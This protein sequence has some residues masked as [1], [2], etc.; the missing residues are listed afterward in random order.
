VVVF[1][2]AEDAEDLPLGDRERH[3]VHRDQRPVGLAQV[4]DL[5]RHDT[6]NR[7]LTDQQY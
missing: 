2:R 1:V 6:H 4:R 5:D 7:L 3:V